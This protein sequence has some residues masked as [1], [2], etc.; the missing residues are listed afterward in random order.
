MSS[1]RALAK[2]EEDPNAIWN[3]AE[4]LEDTQLWAS[5]LAEA[6]FMQ[7]LFLNRL[8]GGNTQANIDYFETVKEKIINHEPFAD[9]YF[10]PDLSQVDVDGVVTTPYHPSDFKYHSSSLFKQQSSKQPDGGVPYPFKSHLLADQHQQ[11]DM[12]G[13]TFDFRSASPVQSNGQENA[14]MACMAECYQGGDN[15]LG[16][17]EHPLFDR[18]S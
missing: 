2:K 17:W 7:D 11:Q 13:S 3:H 14:D 15:G 1:K 16:F 5:R 18:D 6:E 4:S 10:P 8:P 9:E 12:E